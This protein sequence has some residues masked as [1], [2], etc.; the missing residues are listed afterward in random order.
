MW[1]WDR[2]CKGSRLRDQCCHLHSHRD[3]GFSLAQTIVILSV[4]WLA[5]H[6]RELSVTASAQH[7][8]L[9]TRV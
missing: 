1:A 8:K 7:F 9:Y 4:A 5:E 3:A 2:R 6:V